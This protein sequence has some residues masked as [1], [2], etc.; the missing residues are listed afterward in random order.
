MSGAIIPTTRDKKVATPQ[1][2]IK[3]IRRGRFSKSKFQIAPSPGSKAVQPEDR[4][5][6]V[7]HL[8][9]KRNGLAARPGNR[10]HSFSFCACGR[11]LLACLKRFDELGVQNFGFAN[12]NRWHR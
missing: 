7:S 12:P 11:S 6:R 4:K 1:A 9:P 2:V 3:I 10:Q 8:A 5:R